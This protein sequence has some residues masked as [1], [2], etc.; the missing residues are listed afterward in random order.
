MSRAETHEI[1]TG[2]KRSRNG[3][4]WEERLERYPREGIEGPQY[5]RRVSLEG[6]RYIITVMPAKRFL[7][8]LYIFDFKE[9]KN[10]NTKKPQQIHPFSYGLWNRK[11]AVHLC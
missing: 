7:V 4:K 8:F 10:N 3:K 6:D 9:S 11:W 5:S 2:C 1:Q